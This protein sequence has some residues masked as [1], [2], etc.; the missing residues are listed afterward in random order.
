[1][2]QCAQPR[3][4]SGGAKDTE[5]PKVLKLS[6]QNFSTNFRGQTIA[7]EF[8]EY[9]QIRSLN[10]ELVVSPPLNYPVEYRQK[11]KRV[12]FD[13]TDT[14]KPN[15][16]YN[17]NFGNAIVD[18]NENNPLDSNLFVFSTGSTLDSGIIFGTVKD[19]YTQELVKNATVV[20][21]PQTDDSALYTGSPLYI[22]KTNAQGEYLLQFLQNTPYQIFVVE[23]PGEN[24]KYVPLTK[25]GF[26]SS[27]VNPT[28]TDPVNFSVF[29]PI[30]TAQF[31]TKDFSKE[32]FNFNMGFNNPLIK[33]QFTFVP[34]NDTITYII[35][36]I[37][38]DSF[39]FWI[40]G[41]QDI[42]SVTVKTVD[43]KG[44]TDTR[45]IDISE[46]SM[47]L[48]KLKK[49]KQTS[50]PVR[51]SLGSK[52]GVH[53]YFDTL[54]LNFSRPVLRWD[55]DSMLFAQNADT[56]PMHKA[57]T[58]G[59]LDLKLP[60]LEYGTSKELRSIA[61]THIWDPSTDYAF[62]FHSGSFTDIINEVNDSTILKFRTQNFEDYG[63]FRFKVEVPNYSGPLVLQLLNSDG[64]LIRNYYVKS[65][66]EI[67]HELAV[68]GT[69]KFRLILDRNGNKKWD[70]GN[71]D[72]QSQP[73][74]IVY[75]SGS[76]EIR[77]NWDMEETWKVD[78]K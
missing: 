25:V 43:E 3:D 7:M 17:F 69:Y 32:Y 4:L 42:D 14:L 13:I 77:A 56:M 20:L 9:V 51:V 50:S 68:P 16:T 67:Y 37:R 58:S 62:I 33:P 78:L 6:P 60:N 75:Y 65:G 27:L 30:D 44:F 53:H 73:E 55:V 35:E 22:T 10:S 59:L 12:F 41:D 21:Y 74:E 46:K 36:E 2:V 1:M 63:S 47:F 64:K 38:T 72:T 52:N 57:I 8:D 18:L 24:F 66:E 48:K 34:E 19:A 15:T 70:T 28:N 76:I 5:P 31:V 39:K 45:T 49:K 29:K 23:T 71:L 11:G 26:T 61:V 54:R 40:V